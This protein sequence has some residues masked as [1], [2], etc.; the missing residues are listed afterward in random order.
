M[1]LLK[2]TLL[3]SPNYVTTSPE[4]V[5]CDKTKCVSS[6]KRSMLT[7]NNVRSHVME[8]CHFCRIC[9]Y[10][11]GRCVMPRSDLKSWW[12]VNNSTAIGQHGFLAYFRKWSCVVTCTCRRKKTEEEKMTNAFQL[13]N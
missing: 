4:Q 2:A 6:A 3:S 10:K 7:H 5:N 1:S 9:E 12:A 8:Y 11:L 13:S